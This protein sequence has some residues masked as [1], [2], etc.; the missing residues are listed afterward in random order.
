MTAETLRSLFALAFGLGLAGL[1]ASAYQ[2]A[3]TRPLSFRLLNAGPSATALAAVPL[4]VF[5]APF[6]ILRNTI[7]GRRIEGRQFQFTMAATILAGIWSLM[8]GSAAMAG[9]ELVRQILG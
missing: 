1:V 2:L 3:T 6:I 9:L 4:L 5:G 8:S 7:R